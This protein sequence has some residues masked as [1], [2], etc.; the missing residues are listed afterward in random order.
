VGLNE[1][2]LPKEEEVSIKVGRDRPLS[3]QLATSEKRAE[4]IR[5]LKNTR[6]EARVNEAMEKLRGEAQRGE[7]HNLVPAMKDALRADATLGEI[8][9]MI[10][11]ANGTSYDPFNMIQCPI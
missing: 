8:L 1:F 11:E 9:G 10:R 2:V 5:E 6:D 4:R 3:E 7:S